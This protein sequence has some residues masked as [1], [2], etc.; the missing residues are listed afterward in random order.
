MAAGQ[1]TNGHGILLSGHLK[2]PASL[3]NIVYSGL[4]SCALV[5]KR[6]RPPPSEIFPILHGSSV[7][8]A[9]VPLYKLPFVFENCRKYQVCLHLLITFWTAWLSSKFAFFSSF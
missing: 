9:F 6:S 8:L 1:L 2:D 5:L 7:L 4:S 3:N